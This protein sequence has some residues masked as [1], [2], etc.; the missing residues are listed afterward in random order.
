MK[1]LEASMISETR[2]PLN[3]NVQNLGT[4]PGPRQKRERAWLVPCLLIVGPLLLL[5]IYHKMMF[6]GLING[7]ALDFAQLG[8]NISAGR[9]MVTYVLHPLALSYGNNALRQPDVTHGPLYPFLLA[10][11]FGA[12]GAR[13]TVASGVSGFF[14]LLTVPLLYT[15]GVRVFNRAVGLITATAFACSSLMLEYAIS[16]LHI[17]LYTFL[18]TALFLTLYNLA[19]GRKGQA[20]EVSASAQTKLLFLAGAL[21]GLLYLTDTVFFWLIPIMLGSVIWICGPQHRVGLVKF[22]APLCLLTLPWMLRNLLLTGNPV[23]G[24]RGLELWMNTGNYYPGRI[25]YSLY[26]EDF[27]RGGYLIPG[28]IKKMLI[29][30]NTVVQAMP[31][32]SDTWILAFLLPCLLFGYTSQAATMLR[33]V[34]MFSSLA[35]LFGILIFQVDM[36]LF[37]CLVPTMLVFAIAYLTHLVRQAKLST[38]SLGTVAT[39]LGI[40]VAYPLTSQIVLEGKQR[41]LQEIAAAVALGKSAQPEEV[42]LSDSPEIVAW[43]TDRPAIQLPANDTKVADIR[44]RFPKM[45]WLFLTPQAREQS[46]QWQFLY[47]RCVHW[48]RAYLQAQI[49]NSEVPAFMQITG[50]DQPLFKALTGFISVTPLQGS[51]PSTVIAVLPDPKL[52]LDASADHK[53]AP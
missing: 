51:L 26:A 31:Q 42:V 33:R 22:L 29:G 10:L 48:N 47:D 11:A 6:P 5:G 36:P 12:A 25:A 40:T 43:Y 8:R 16:G 15:L 45:R 34:M 27:R 17:T 23:F 35:L 19:A 44:G 9:G 30:M 14:Y 18:V 1:E 52:S 39:L 53:V 37:S 20:K 28:V 7:G 3:S 46:A 13:D 38:F 32:I 41:P 21:T 49:T 2:S 50:D 24:L 4:Q